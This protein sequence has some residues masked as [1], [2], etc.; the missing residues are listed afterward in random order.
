MD[1]KDVASDRLSSA[2]GTAPKQA[3]EAKAQHSESMGQGATLWAAM[4]RNPRMPGRLGMRVRLTEHV[5]YVETGMHTDA[6]G[7]PLAYVFDVDVRQG[8]TQKT[9]GVGEITVHVRR[10]EGTE[11]AVLEDMPDFRNGAQLISEASKRARF[12]E[13]QS[14]NVR[15]LP[16]PPASDPF[17]PE[18]V[19]LAAAHAPMA[20]LQRLNIL[21]EAGLIT[22]DQY[23]AKK[24]Q[25]IERLLVEGEQ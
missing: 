2:A 24:A 10:P 8:M 7:I 16:P 5:L 15:Y 25:I 6:L 19:L 14:T 11:T 21:R 17:P 13:A 12:A 1:D 18:G 23:G 3:E 20:Q 9:A 4:G 22:E